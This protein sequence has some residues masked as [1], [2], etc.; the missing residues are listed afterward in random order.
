MVTMNSPELFQA[1]KETSSEL[2]KVNDRINGLEEKLNLALS[3]NHQPSSL[4]TK[5]EVARN[6]N[7]SERHVTYLINE[8]KCLPFVKEG[9]LVKIRYEHLQKYIDS[10]HPKNLSD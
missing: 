9:V 4:L 8:K 5:R 2:K 6:L 10:L 1:L 3:N 7:C